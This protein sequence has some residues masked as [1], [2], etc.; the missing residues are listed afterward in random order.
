MFLYFVLFYFISFYFFFFWGGGGSEWGLVCGCHNFIIA[1]VK[2]YFDK[3]VLF[4]ALVP[5]LQ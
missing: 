3:K 2:T 1:N 4:S 5:V